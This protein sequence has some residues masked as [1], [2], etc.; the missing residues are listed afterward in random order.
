MKVFCTVLA[1]SLVLA[2]A[3]FADDV[4]LS[5]ADVWHTVTGY[6]HTHFGPDPIPADF[7][8]K[9]S[10][11]FAGKVVLRGVPLVT[12]PPGVLG[13][14]DTIVHRLDNAHFDGDGVART[15]LKVLAMTLESIEPVDV[16]CGLYDVKVTL[17][18]DQPMTEMKIRREADDGGT[19]AAPLSLETRVAF[20]PVDGDGETVEL[21]RRVDLGPGMNTH[22]STTDMVGTVDGE[23]VRVDSDG[24]GVADTLLPRRSNFRAGLMPASFETQQPSRCY[25][26]CHCTP[27]GQNP[28]PDE[29]SDT[30]TH[31]HC[32]EITPS[33]E[34][35]GPQT[36][37]L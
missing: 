32:T 28:S 35:C 17:A 6:S 27:W 15:R 21:F 33:G 8:C 16:G 19:Y 3:A 7:F 25:T 5:G 18:G 31:L 36:E 20:T 14:A 11:P 4:I 9:G 2:P 26:V 12:E 37:Q 23:G 10:P 1:L 29:P 30:C 22:W 13:T 34:P 24:D